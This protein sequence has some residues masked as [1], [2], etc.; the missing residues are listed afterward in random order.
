MFVTSFSCI[1]S[2]DSGY[3]YIAILWLI[4]KL[5]F[6]A[7]SHWKEKCVAFEHT[8]IVQIFLELV[9]TSIG[10]FYLFWRF[11]AGPLRNI[12]LW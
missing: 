2:I 8:M 6:D 4:G 7:E 10:K 11:C 12:S 9:D 3:Y 1:L 5:L